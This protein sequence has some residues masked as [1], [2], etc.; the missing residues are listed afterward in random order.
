MN[1]S[2]EEQDDGNEIGPYGFRI[3]H[4]GDSGCRIVSFKPYF[5]HDGWNIPFDVYLGAL[6]GILWG[7]MEYKTTS[8]QGIYEDDFPHQRMSRTSFD[9]EWS[10]PNQIFDPMESPY[11]TELTNGNEAIKTPWFK[12][13]VFRYLRYEAV[14][15]AKLGNY[16]DVTEDSEYKSDVNEDI[17]YRYESI[18]YQA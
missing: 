4:V 14:K 12:E 3:R 18:I 5:N 17:K 9:K 11:A 13:Q 6:R 8:M 10:G 15:R 1:A 2:R 7:E 16:D